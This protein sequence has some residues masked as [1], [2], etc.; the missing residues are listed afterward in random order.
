MS[1]TQGQMM[2]PALNADMDDNAD[3]DAAD[4]ATLD[5]GT[6]AGA[7]DLTRLCTVVT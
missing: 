3:D 1:I 2:Y 7:N 4:V 5:D 6:T